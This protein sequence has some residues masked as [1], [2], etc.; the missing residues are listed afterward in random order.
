M[1]NYFFNWTNDAP[2]IDQWFK[3]HHFIKITAPL[4]IGYSI[5]LNEGDLVFVHA[6]DHSFWIEKAQEHRSIDFVFMSRASINR[7]DTWTDNIHICKYPADK[8]MESDRV[9]SFFSELLSGNRLWYLLVPDS[10]THLTA[11]SILCQGYLAA[12]G[13]KESLNGWDEVWNKLPDELKD[14][15]NL[16]QLVK[17]KINDTEE[18]NWWTDAID[19]EEAEKQLKEKGAN[20]A[21]EALLDAI[22][23]KNRKVFSG[24]DGIKIVESA[25][26]ALREILKEKS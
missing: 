6:T 15:E 4:D 11:L 1:A 24:S 13:V 9:K 10:K 17:E 14:K 18:L 16:Y 25:N 23:K 26:K 7:E 21:V 12:H 8:L 22:N 20:G 19:T 5:L 2:N 3:D